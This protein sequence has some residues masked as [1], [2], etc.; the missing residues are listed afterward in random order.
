[1]S[2]NMCFSSLFHT[3][4]LPWSLVTSHSTPQSSFLL[5][6]LALAGNLEDSLLQSC[7]ILGHEQRRAPN[8]FLLFN[9]FYKFDFSWLFQSHLL[10]PFPLP[11][12]TGWMSLAC[13]ISRLCPEISF[14]KPKVPSH[15]AKSWQNLKKSPG[16]STYKAL[17]KESDFFTRN[18]PG[19]M[20]PLSLDSIR[21]EKPQVCGSPLSLS[22]GRKQSTGSGT[23]RG[24]ISGAVRSGQQPSCRPKIPRKFKEL[25]GPNPHQLNQ[26]HRTSW[27]KGILRGNQRL[28]E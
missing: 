5:G 27:S 28:W 22:E 19:K 26:S 16:L 1:M 2:D 14:P 25:H 13:S 15:K 11:P 4:Q 8:S 21:R 3:L 24:C 18:A 7:L 23:P 17:T 6:H 10:F 9:K 20:A 12:S